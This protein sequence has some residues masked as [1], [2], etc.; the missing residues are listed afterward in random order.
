MRTA[1]ADAAMVRQARPQAFGGRR[2][3]RG[4]LPRPRG[5]QTS[6]GIQRPIS[7]TQS[8]QGAGHARRNGDP[9]I[10]RGAGRA[11]YTDSSASNADFTRVQVERAQRRTR[12]PPLKTVISPCRRYAN[13]PGKARGRYPAP[14]RLRPPRGAAWYA[15]ATCLPPTSTTRLCRPRCK[16]EAAD[17]AAAWR[18][19]FYPDLT[20]GSSHLHRSQRM[21][22]VSTKATIPWP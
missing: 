21:Q 12:G 14:S 15:N 20:C 9:E 2:R 19:E 8:R 7:N 4:Q 11:R 22:G 17:A 13:A 6:S 16:A 18:P 10:F 3:G 5:Q 1:C